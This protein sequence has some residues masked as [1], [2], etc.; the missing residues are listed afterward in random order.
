MEYIYGTDGDCQTL[1]TVGRTHSNLSGF[2]TSS[3]ES[4]GVTVIDKCRILDHYKAD[5]DDEGTCYDWYHIADRDHY[6]DRTVAAA[7][8]DNALAELS[9]IVMDH[10]EAMAELSELVSEIIEGGK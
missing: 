4:S 5:E 1:K 6:E 7:E 10:E 9:Q 3:R 2:F 8:N